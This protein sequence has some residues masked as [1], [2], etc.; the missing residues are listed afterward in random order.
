LA[1]DAAIADIRLGNAGEV[2]DHLRDSHYK[3]AKELQ[4]GIGYQYPHNFEN[5][6]VDQQYLPDKIKDAH[7]YEPKAT[8]KYEQALGQQYQRKNG[9]R[10][11]KMTFK[12]R[13]I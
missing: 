4:R 8:G 2:P 3:G 13:V 7:Y 9:K 1:L 11:N 5:A 6:W 10:K 12:V